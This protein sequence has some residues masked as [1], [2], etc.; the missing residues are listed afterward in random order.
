MEGYLNH[1]RVLGIIGELFFAELVER[2]IAE[3]LRDIEELLGELLQSY[4]VILKS[5]WGIR[6]TYLERLFDLVIEL[7]SPI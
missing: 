3:L 2:V 5:Y 4:C 7:I 1:W 6:S